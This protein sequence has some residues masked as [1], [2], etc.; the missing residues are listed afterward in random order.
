MR[1]LRPELS[2]NESAFQILHAAESADA[3]I[4]AFKLHPA[5]EQYPE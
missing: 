1:T 4:E 5:A 3:W 2:A